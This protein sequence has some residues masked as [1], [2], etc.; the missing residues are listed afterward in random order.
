[1][2][3][4]YPDQDIYLSILNSIQ[5]EIVFCDVNHKVL[6]INDYA[7]EKYKDSNL[8]IGDSIFSCH[9]NG[10]SH[11]IIKESFSKLENGENK[12]FLYKSEKT[13]SDAYLIAIRDRNRDLLGYWEQKS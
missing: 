11:K 3:S 1:M 2:T 6:F 4:N 5:T 10:N 12:V 7:K 13:G 8:K 9:K